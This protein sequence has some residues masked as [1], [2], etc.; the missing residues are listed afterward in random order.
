MNEIKDALDSRL[1]DITFS[2]QMKNKVL[3]ECKQVKKE[4]YNV[5]SCYLLPQNSS[6][7]NFFT[8]I[9]Y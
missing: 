5:D 8:C 4:S 7:Y 2:Q 1:K 3:E 9:L 6:A